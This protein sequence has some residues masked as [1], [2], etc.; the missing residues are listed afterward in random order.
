MA[1]AYCAWLFDVLF[2]LEGELDISQYD[3]VSRRVFGYVAE[4]L[5][6]VWMDTHQISYRELPVVNL[7]RQ[8]WIK[9][10][11]NFLLRK[12]R[13]IKNDKTKSENPEYYQSA[14]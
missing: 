13:G 9:K 8:N 1:D 10:G 11:G 12:W 6:D 4:R 5:L 2:R 7:E 14:K 3:A